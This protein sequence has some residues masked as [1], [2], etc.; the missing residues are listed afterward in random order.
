MTNE[1]KQFPL[2][3][4]R[5][6]LVY[7]TMV[8]HLDVGR[9]KSVLA[10][11]QAMM[12]DQ[13]IFLSTQ[14]K[15]SMEDPAVEDIY[16]I[17]T[18][19]KIN[20]MLKLPSGTVRVLVEGLYRAKIDT[21]IENDEA[22]VVNVTKVS[23]TYEDE[24]KEE[25]LMRILLEQFEQYIQISGKITKETFATVSDIAEPNRLADIVA[26]HLPIKMNEKQRILEET[27]VPKRLEMLI[28][29]ISDE[30]NVLTLE[31][32]IGQRVKSSM[33]QTQKEYYLREQLKAIQSELGDREGKTGEV[34]ELREKIEQSDMLDDIKEIALKELHRYEQVPQTSGESAVIRNYLEWL[35]DLP[36]QEKTEDVLD[37]IKAKNILDEDH[38]GL[39]KV[40]E[41]ILE[42]LAVQK[43]TEKIRGPIIC[44]VGP[45]GVG[46]TSLAQS[47]ARAINRKFVRIS[48]GGVRDE[49]EIRGH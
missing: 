46:K 1:V 33:E 4:L 16:S 15:I 48:L 44:L 18:V 32:E 13:E 41:R 40:K 24:M 47:I 28:D 3:P 34:N 6:I 12:D 26:S 20:Q 25:A 42:Y 17:G 35:V 31:K 27:S 19:A 39:E 22:F 38:Y 37:V 7:P 30:K 45:P 29:L 43:L 9:D 2:L 21:Y 5:G 49:A 36:W 11:E 23:E 14:K 8:L 10:L